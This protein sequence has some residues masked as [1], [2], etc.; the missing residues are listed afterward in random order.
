M[1]ELIFHHYPPSPVAEK[2]RKTF[3]IKGLSWAS[4]EENRLPPRLELFAMT[5]G[6]RRIPVMQIG[7]DIY[8]DTQCILRELDKRFPTPALAPAGRC[9]M[10]FALSRFTDSEMFTHAFKAVLAP[11]A[12]KLPPA[13]VADRGRLYLGPDYDMAK[14]AADMPHTLSQLRPM[15]GWVD[16]CLRETG[17]FITGD[18]AKMPD[19]LVWYLVWFL[20]GRWA[21]AANFFEEF[22]GVNQW[23]DRMEAIGQGDM[24]EI[25]P[26]DALAVCKAA[27]PMTAEASDDR[28][29]QG[30]KVGMNVSVEPLTDSGEEAVTGTLRVVSRD[31]VT[32]TLINDE[33]G[34]HAVHF[35]RVGYRV[36]VSG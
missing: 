18:D 9:G 20:K 25:S 21:D 7:A 6:Y 23:A 5:G 3:V 22:D 19:I 30:L 31:S 27:M 34:E 33:A 12:A 10:A 36:R 35:P 29:P 17:A 11:A 8:C 32:L 24:S 14:E 15:L 28:D 16:D 26:Q 4:C 2:V 1:S 13:F